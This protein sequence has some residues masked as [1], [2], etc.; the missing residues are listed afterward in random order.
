MKHLFPFLGGLVT[1]M[2]I[3]TIFYMGIMPYPTSSCVVPE[4]QMN[5]GAM[6]LGNVLVVG[7]AVYLVHLGGGF[8]AAN[9]A[10]HGAV[11][12]LTANG[13]L[14]IFVYAFFTCDGGHI[15]PLGEAIIDIVVGVVCVPSIFQG[16]FQPWQP[17]PW[18]HL[19]LFWRLQL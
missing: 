11:A 12:G 3:S 18:Q 17:R 8:S 5:M 6:L 7:L 10:R 15:F 14:N 9:G 19:Q 13:F 1:F 2:V 4:D 16:S